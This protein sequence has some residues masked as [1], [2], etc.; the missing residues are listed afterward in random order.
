MQSKGLS[1]LL[2]IACVA[3]LS[4]VGFASACQTDSYANYKLLT[5]GCVIDDKTFSDFRYT[6]G[7]PNLGI[8]PQN[9]TVTPLNDAL[10]PGFQF[11][12]GWY[13][14]NPG[15]LNSMD[16]LIQYTVNVNPGGRPITDVSLSIGGS[17]WNTTGGVFVDETVCLGAVFPACSGGTEEQLHVYD[18]AAGT[19]LFDEISFA[20]VTEVDVEKDILV[21]AGSD[22]NGSARLSLVT[23]QFSEQAPEP[24]SILLFGSGALVYAGLLRRKLSR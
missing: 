18:S 17:G 4:G 2:V 22:A 7:P 20:G 1:A 9:L 10:G 8:S 13:A 11:S 23:N 6:Y 19:K 3:L 5:S 21:E 14:S 24:S 16:S 12:A 15:G